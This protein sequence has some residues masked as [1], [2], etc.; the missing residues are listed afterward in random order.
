MGRLTSFLIVLFLSGSAALAMAGQEKEPVLVYIGTYTKDDGQGI[1]LLEMDPESGALT[2]KGVVAE[3]ENPSFLTLHPNHRFLYA[4]NEVGEY[5]GTPGGGVTAFEIDR[6]SGALKLLNHQSSKGGDPCHITI[7]SEGRHVLIAN[8]SGGSVAVLPVQ[9]DG[10]LAEAS[11]FEQHQGTGTDPGRQRGPHGHSINLDPT[12]AFAVAA[13]LG[14]DQLLVYK[15]DVKAGTLTANDPPFATLAPSSG[16]RHFD[17]HPNGRLAFAINELA[18]T[19]TAFQFDPETGI[20]TETQTLS[21]LPQDF[22]G[23]SYTADI[24]VHPSGRFLYG[25]NRGHDSIAIFQIDEQAGTLT[26]LGHQSTGGETP[27]NFG[28]DPTGQFLLAAN[29]GTNSVVVF[30]I[31][32]ETGALIP[33][34]HQVEVPMPVCVKFMPDS[35]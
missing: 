12:E 34:G 13:D 23:T 18:S 9:P 5:K 31:E 33:T 1:N 4:V 26:P 8:Y 14:L 32:T 28:I 19:V 2:L 15:Y 16:P 29:Q 10:S 21:S 6:D 30:R 7:D 22:E 20:L 17:F 35:E 27:R 24:H 25:S 11:D 3:T